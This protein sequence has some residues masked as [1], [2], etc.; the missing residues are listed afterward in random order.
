MK[1]A[2]TYLGSSQQEVRR[3]SKWIT[4]AQYA[5]MEMNHTDAANAS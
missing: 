1:R 2:T 5:Y 3:A 4:A